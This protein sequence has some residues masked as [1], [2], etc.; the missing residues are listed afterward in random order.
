MNELKDR[1]VIITGSTRGFGFWTAQ[2]ML[3]AGATV[4]ISGRSPESLQ[5]AI[6]SLEVYGQVAG[7]VCDMRD[8]KQVYALARQAVEKFGHIDV[9][10]NNAGF[11]AGAGMLLDIR[12]EQVVD[13][14]M[15]NDMGTLYGTQAALHYMLPAKRGT[16]INIYGAGSNGKAASPMGMYATTKMWITSFTRTL[17]TEIKGSGVKLLAFSPGMMLTDM[18][19]N[20]IVVGERG[21]MKMQNFGFVLRF[22]AKPPQDAARLL[23]RA[24]A[25]NHKEFAE[26]HA[27]KPWSPMFGLVRVAWENLFKTGKTPEYTLH[28]EEAYQPE[29]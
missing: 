27:M 2:E 11:S 28:F 10:V 17:A 24:L 18:L 26:I 4:I 21:K 7:W 1:I 29:I 25:N 19:A 20:P 22:L 12:P 23:V 6:A 5:A 9:W 13:M 14:F 15:S 16:L 3:K 8:E